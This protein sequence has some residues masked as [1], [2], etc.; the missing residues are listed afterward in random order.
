LGV[1]PAL[2]Q[3]AVT[4]AI[5]AALSANQAELTVFGLF[6]PPGEK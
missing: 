6:V 4:A 5:D 3:A 1:L 2:D